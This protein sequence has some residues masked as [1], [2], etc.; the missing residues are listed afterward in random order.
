[1]KDM[2]I[3]SVVHVHKHAEELAIDAPDSCGER[4]MEGVV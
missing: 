3:V 2:R 1:M 4:G